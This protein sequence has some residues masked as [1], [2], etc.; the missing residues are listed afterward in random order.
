MHISEY[1]HTLVNQGDPVYV[2]G[3][4]PAVVLSSTPI[5]K[6]PVFPVAPIPGPGT[7]TPTAPPAT[8]PPATSTPPST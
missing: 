7:P 5:N 8:A 6:G 3:G 4:K 1:F 2:D